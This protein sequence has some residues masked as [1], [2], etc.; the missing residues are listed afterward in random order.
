MPS[1][2]YDNLMRRLEQ[3]SAEIHDVREAVRDNQ[4]ILREHIVTA[5]NERKEITERIRHALHGGNGEGLGIY[6]RFRNIF[7]WRQEH[8]N[9]H[10]HAGQ[11]RRSASQDWRRF[12]LDVTKSSLTLVL[13]VAA[14]LI[15][16][17]VTGKVISLP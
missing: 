7:D 3:L 12:A 6:E 15:V 9:S 5:D 10:E 14:I 8:I 16:F 17:A 2:Q 13:A 11:E 1:S 4:R